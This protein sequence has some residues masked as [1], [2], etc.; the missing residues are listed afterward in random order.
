MILGG[1]EDSTSKGTWR[2][3]DTSKALYFTQLAA[4]GYGLSDVEQL[5]VEVKPTTPST[6]TAGDEPAENDD[7]ADGEDQPLE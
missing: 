5:A 4:W 3:P 6:K 1:I 2:Y 7:Q